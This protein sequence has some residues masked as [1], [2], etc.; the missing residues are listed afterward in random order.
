MRDFI[1]YFI[2]DLRRDLIRNLNRESIIEIARHKKRLRE[3]GSGIFGAWNKRVNE[4]LETK[5]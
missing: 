5:S 3:F 4:R 1:R 2:R